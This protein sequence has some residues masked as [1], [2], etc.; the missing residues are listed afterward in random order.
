MSMADA[1]PAHFH[2]PALGGGSKFASEGEANFG[3]GESVVG[4]EPPPQTTFSG[5]TLPEGRVGRDDKP[6]GHAEAH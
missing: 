4:T 3:A 5:L 6:T 1:A 2:P